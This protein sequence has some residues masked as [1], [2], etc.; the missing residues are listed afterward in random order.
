MIAIVMS[1]Y[2]RNSQ[3]IKTLK[4]F[5]E[6]S[7][8]DISVYIVDDCSPED[9][10]LP[11]FNFDITIIKLFDKHWNNCSVVFNTGFNEALKD[12]PDIV[13]ITNPECYHVGDVL[14]YALTVTDKTYIS[15]GCYGLDKTTTNSDYE[16]DEVI[17]KDNRIIT[18]NDGDWHTHN[19][20]YNHP[21]IDP[22]GFHYCSAITTKNLIKI[23]G[24]E[25]RFAYGI[26][27]EDDYLIRQIK[28]LGLKIE[29][30]EKP[31]VVHQWHNSSQSMKESK[32]LWDVNEKILY[33]LITKKTYKA[34]HIM[35]PDLCGI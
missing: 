20:W 34:V 17:K 29:I 18:L 3:L 10:K 6:S 19:G 13:I 32:S 30:T 1:Y 14:N 26:S 24:F 9:I 11:E 4:S 8:K 7:Y 25:E 2:D 23:N 22:V 16:I 15:F 28:N 35:T 12:K 31:F 33:Q 21:T 5:E 27:F